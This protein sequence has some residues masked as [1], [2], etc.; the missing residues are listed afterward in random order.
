MIQIS[1]LHFW[2]LL[3]LA[4]SA[5]P[6]AIYVFRHVVHSPSRR[7]IT[8][9]KPDLSWRSQRQFIICVFA[10]I[11]LSLVAGFSFTSMAPEL[12]LSP[13]YLPWLMIA[14]GS[15]AA[16]TVIRGLIVE[17]IEPLT[18]GRVGPY[19]RALQPKRFWASAMW[20]AVLSGSCF[21]LAF[22]VFGQ[23]SPNPN[24][25]KCFDRDQRFLPIEAL[26]ACNKLLDTPSY[27]GKDSTWRVY[28]ARGYAY[29]RLDDLD[30][31]IADYSEAIRLN[32]L[33]EYPLMNRANAYRELGQ[34][35]LAL[36]DYNLV[37][38]LLPNLADAFYFRA[39]VHAR[40]GDKMLA[41]EDLKKASE[42][43]RTPLIGGTGRF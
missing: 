31:A 6:P 33:S 12:R 10:L 23:A 38:R 11:C 41:D 37:I 14:F 5:L 26:A 28:N 2:F 27:L 3:L 4:L 43:R 39:L 30:R 24:Q 42:L 7:D 13:E 32:P 16:Y 9:P 35:S 18:R 29:D 36:S 1:Q 8:Q 25:D 17:S 34:D 40:L 21:W 20:N 22:Q 19:S 15:G